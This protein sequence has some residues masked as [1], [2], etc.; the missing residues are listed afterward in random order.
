MSTAYV[1]TSCLVA[2]ALGEPGADTIARRLERHDRLISSNLLEAEF[3]AALKRE[4][5]ASDFDMLNGF[6]WILPSRP[7]RDEIGRVLEARRL[8]GAG[9]W[10][11]ATAL[12]L[13]EDPSEL[14]FLTMDAA[15][16]RVAE[17]LGFRI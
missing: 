8:R 17:A 5:V 16:R 12:Y 15:Q 1:D 11:L 9:C 10:H 4:G 2:I 6:A 13:A 7:L 3:R 14:A